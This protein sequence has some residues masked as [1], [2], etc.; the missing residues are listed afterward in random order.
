[1][2]QNPLSWRFLSVFTLALLL[3][4]PPSNVQGK[5]LEKVYAVINGEIITLTEIKDYQE[6]LNHGGLS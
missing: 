5:I 2:Q 6:K 1:M 3:F 4:L